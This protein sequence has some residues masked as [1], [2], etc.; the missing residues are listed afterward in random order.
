MSDYYYGQG[1][2]FVARRQADGTAG[3]FV[4]L[5]DVSQLHLTLTQKSL[6]KETALQGR[7]GVSDIYVYHQALNVSLSLMSHSPDNVARVLWGQVQTHYAGEINE[8]TLPS[9]VQ[10]GDR[11]T[12]AHPGVWGLTLGELVQDVDY[13][14]DA[15]F[16]AVTFLTSPPSPLSAR[17]YHA[18]RDAIRLFTTQPEECILRYEGL[19]LA[20]EHRVVLMELYRVQ[21]MPAAVFTLLNNDSELLSLDVEAQVLMMPYAQSDHQLDRFGVLS[22]VQRYSS[23]ITLHVDTV[24]FLPNALFSG[25]IIPNWMG[26]IPA[27]AI[28]LDVVGRGLT[29]TLVTHSQVGGDYEVSADFLPG[30]YQAQAQANIVTPLNG[31]QTV[32][33]NWIDFDIVGGRATA[34]I[35]LTQ[36]AQA[37]CYVDKAEDTGQIW[38]S[39]DGGE[40]HQ[41]YTINAYGAVVSTRTLPLNTPIT[42][43]ITNSDTVVFSHS[44]NA[45]DPIK[46]VANLLRLV[47]VSGSRPAITRL[48]YGQSTLTEVAEGVFDKLIRLSSADWVFK[49]CTGLTALPAKLF[50][51][52]PHVTTFTQTFYECSGLT[53]LPAD[54]F[55]YTPNAQSFVYTFSYCTGLTQLPAG[56]FS[57]LSQATTFSQAFRFCSGLTALPADTFSGCQKATSFNYVFASCTALTTLPERIF[58]DCS[59]ALNFSNAFSNCTG[60][61]RVPASLFSHNTLVTTFQSVFYSCYALTTLPSTL[62]AGQ[63]RVTTYASAFANCRQLTQI[64]ATLFADSPVVGVFQSVFSGCSALTTLPAHLFRVHSKATSLQSAFSGCSGLKRIESELFAGA[65]SIETIASLFEGCSAL[66]SIPEGLLQPLVNVKQCT[67]VFASCSQLTTLPSTLF[68]AQTKATTFFGVLNGCEQLTAIPEGLFANNQQVTTFAQAFGGCLQLTA[69]PSNVFAQNNKVT[70]FDSAFEGCARLSQVPAGLFA[71]NS[72]ASNL[73]RTFADCLE[74]RAVGAGLLGSL[75][76]LNNL[77]GT[78]SGCAK[79]ASTVE[80]IFTTAT[81]ARLGYC[82]EMFKGCAALRGEA[83]PFIARHQSLVNTSSRRQGAFAGCETLVDYQDIPAVWR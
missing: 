7:R 53:A 8:E 38:L 16:G 64:P 30:R 63:A 73:T 40:S 2:V 44:E 48:C 71:H 72:A 6:S 36:Q 67:R 61:L 27:T 81:F 25:R 26:E 18:A 37:L 68:A 76:G 35:M 46:R 28:T 3:P 83:M 51:H 31:V 54:L 29:K 33:S 23:A 62:F 82:T 49:G 11:I 59:N 5:G 9:N 10:R 60:L 79:L 20:S 14:L 47:E 80:S 75:T 22:W 21:F 43:T 15:L 50:A 42:L 78:F 69:V 1:R 58:Q 32:R 57:G 52:N 56:L 66:T 70:T 17:Y 39:Y 19:D 65:T 13:Q 77:T 74:L 4:W 34:V 41:D 24:E 45:S 12:L 55:R